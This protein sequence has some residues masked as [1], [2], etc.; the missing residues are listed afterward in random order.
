DCIVRYGA[1]GALVIYLINSKLYL[2]TPRELEELAGANRISDVIRKCKSLK[3]GDGILISICKLGDSN[4]PSY[5]VNA[6]IEILG[7]VDC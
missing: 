7:K 1:E 4:C 6:A 5:V 2:P 3:S